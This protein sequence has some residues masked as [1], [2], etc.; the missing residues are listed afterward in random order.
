MRVT[1]ELRTQKSFHQH[2]L[3]SLLDT[4][5]LHLKLTRSTWEGEEVSVVHLQCAPAVSQ[6]RFFKAIHVFATKARPQRR[7]KSNIAHTVAF[8][9]K[10]DP[11]GVI[12]YVSGFPANVQLLRSSSP[13]VLHDCSFKRS[14]LILYITQ[15]AIGHS[16]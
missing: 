11:R 5:H 1:G 3:V 8:G 16:S 2:H 12:L 6:R 4:V 14:Y 13:G 9:V 10:L 7:K 15:K